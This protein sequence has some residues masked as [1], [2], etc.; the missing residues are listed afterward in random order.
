MFPYAPELAAMAALFV[1]AL[2]G[3]AIPM[4][5][6]RGGGGARFFPL[7]NAFAAGLFLSIGFLHL[8]PESTAKLEGLADY[9]LAPLLAAAG[10]LVLLLIDR[11]V[12]TSR[13]DAS[14]LRP[15]ALLA[16]LSVH[17]FVV[18]VALGLDARVTTSLAILAGILFHKA[19]DSFVLIVSAHMAGMEARLQKIV[20]VSF[21]AVT[22][23]GV[24]VGSALSTGLAESAAAAAMEGIFGALAAGAFFYI[25][26]VVIMDR[27]FMRPD[28]ASSGGGRAPA[29]DPDR[30]AKA[31]LVFA[32]LALA[33]SSAHHDT[34]GHGGTH[35]HDASGHVAGS[36]ALDAVRG[37]RDAPDDGHG[38]EDGHGH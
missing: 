10:L 5:A 31:G 13:A 23:A 9:P 12:A 17:S 30:W 27:E 21:A 16:A 20:L 18:G 1:A 22:P 14:S 25:A 4:R 15:W 26:V 2:I 29:R 32:G 19:S 36:A 24:A 37:V 11:A 8:L 7:G 3:G 38:H 6:A 35:A 28:A 33:A 34:H